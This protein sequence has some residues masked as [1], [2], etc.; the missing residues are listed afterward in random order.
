MHTGYSFKLNGIDSNR[1]LFFSVYAFKSC[2]TYVTRII[3][4]RQGCLQIFYRVPETANAY[5]DFLSRWANK[6][7]SRSNWTI[8]RKILGKI[9]WVLTVVQEAFLNARG[10]LDGSAGELT[11]YLGK[12]EILFGE[13]NGSPYSVWIRWEAS[14]NIGCDLRGCHLFYSFQSVQLICIYFV[15]DSSPT[16]SY[17]IV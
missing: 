12:P 14:E 8:A 3:Q 5:L 16:T 9:L 15:A 13:S 10:I 1:Q 11:I 6:L 17:I 2:S 4:V 7:D